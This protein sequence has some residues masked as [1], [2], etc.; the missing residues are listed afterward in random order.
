M[1]RWILPEN[2]NFYKANLHCH[3][4]FS[5]GR[6]TPAQIREAYRK[7]GYSIVAFT[8]HDVLLPH[9]ELR[10]ETFLPMHGFEIEI[11]EATEV[12]ER[13]K[14]CH[15]CFVSLDEN[16]T[17]QPIWHRTD[18]LFGNAPSHRAEVR[19][20]PDVPDFV[21]S[22]TPECV[23]E[24][25]RIGKE[26]GFFVTYNHPIWSLESYPEYGKYEGMD[27]MEI[28]NY[29]CVTAGYDDRNGKVY[30]D[31]L[32][33]G[34]RLFCIAADD[35]HNGMG[36]TDWNFDSF[37]GFIVI[38]A[39]ALTYPLIAEALKNGAF[40]ASE[41]PQIEALRYD[42]ETRELY[43]RT[44]PAVRITCT[45]AARR[46][47]AAD[48]SRKGQLVTEASFTLDPTDLYAR[49]TVRDGT[50]KCAFSNAIFDL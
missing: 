16:N 11:N 22:Y 19:F 50:G 1:T 30:D 29:G 26:H 23:N 4:T 48:L 45:T 31:L 9:P 20:D 2:G 47:R 25:I 27:A 17:T 34:K 10:D 8:D 13:K 18:Y 7:E 41:G 28:V 44:S 6:L 12:W 33:Q 40:Y 24:A 49:I 3:S 36:L 15:L 42:E 14:T 5:D 46:D 32:R 37:G 39:P 21:R 35:N 38:K 43:V